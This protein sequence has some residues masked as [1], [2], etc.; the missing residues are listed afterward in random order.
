MIDDWRQISIG[1]VG[2]VV[3]GKTPSSKTPQHFGDKMPFV[4]PTDFGNYHKY[5]ESAE[6]YLS[7]EGV[8]GLLSR[9]LPPNT[10]IVTCIRSDMGKVAMNRVEC[11]TNQ[12]INSI[13][14][15]A[16]VVDSH[17]VY[18]CLKNSYSLLRRLA[19]DGTTMPIVNKGDFE[20]IRIPYPRLPIQHR[21]AEI[22]GALDDKIE[23]NRRMNATLE[24]MADAFFKYWFLDTDNTWESKPFDEV[25]TFLNGLALQKYPPKDGASLPVIK[26][27]EMH[28]GVTESSDRASAEIPSQYIVHDGDVLFSWSGSLEVCVWCNGRGALNQ[29]LFKVTSAEY[30]KWFY[31]QWLKYHLP[32]FR[33]IAAG[34]AT[35]MGHIQRE[36]LHQASVIIPPQETLHTMNAKMQPM[37][38]QIISNNLESQTLARTRD[39]LLPKLLS[40]EVTI[41][42]IDSNL[43]TMP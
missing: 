9:V 38:D 8:Q 12:Q 18:Y 6:R 16:N 19:E 2:I 20:R 13:I 4:T 36:H 27:A 10:V 24:A 11:I 5:I 25:A 42:D 28:R 33:A 1:E 29:H 17:W 32:E 7:T 14:C 22:L 41:K 3:T 26:I 21:I 40:G 15:D 23:C 31:Y 30:P 34:K 43:E 39:Y 35:T 37:L